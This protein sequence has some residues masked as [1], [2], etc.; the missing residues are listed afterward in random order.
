MWLGFIQEGAYALDYFPVLPWFGLVLLGIYYG[1]VLYPEGK[2]SFSLKEKSNVAT[3]FLG[4][5]GRNSLKI[6]LVHQPI[7]LAFLYLMT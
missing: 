6:Y 7:I 2:R 3:R 1:G 4:F 5:L